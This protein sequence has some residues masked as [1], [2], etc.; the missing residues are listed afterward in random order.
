MVEWPAPLIRE[1]AERRVVLFVGSGVSKSAV[2]TLPSWTTLLLQMAER[3]KLKKDK[4]LAKRLVHNSR[5]LDAAEL[6]NSLLTPA[7]RRQ[8]LEEIFLFA[9][10][11]ISE[12]YEQLLMCDFK[13]CIT[14]NYDELLE[15]NFEHFSA[16]AVAYQTRKYQYDNILADLRSPTRIILKLHGCITEP[17]NIILDRESFFRAKSKYSG[18]YDI[19]TAISTVSTILFLGYSIND[20]DIQLILE[21][22]H[23]RIHSDHTHYALVPK[24]EHP[25]L[26]SALSKT[27]NVKF[28]EYSGKN[29]DEFQNA[30]QTLRNA[31]KEMRATRGIP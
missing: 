17:A 29:H 24:F 26:R 3:A 6:V 30:V 25:S 10:T 4:A 13:I 19:V 7:D 28:L 2:P 9:K 27:F 20:P 12:I 11:P 8:F 18:V 22:I 16:G 23:A 5:L 31:V 15:K 1:I 14:T 21:G